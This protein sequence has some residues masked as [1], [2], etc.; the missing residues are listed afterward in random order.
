[1]QTQDGWISLDI[2]VSSGAKRHQ[3]QSFAGISVQV[4]GSGGN[5]Q[6]M[7]VSSD[8]APLPTVGSKCEDLL[9][10]SET[11]QH[12]LFGEQQQPTQ[13]SGQPPPM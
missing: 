10:R 5:I 6:E 1:M 4:L 8:Y 3:D 7:L 11:D 13:Q 12:L 9:H 2:E